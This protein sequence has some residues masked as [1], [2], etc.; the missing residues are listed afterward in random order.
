M[1]ALRRQDACVVSER[2]REDLIE[3]RGDGEKGMS[4]ATIVSRGQEAPVLGGPQRILGEG[5]EQVFSEDGSQV[6]QVG[7]SG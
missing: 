4:S 2:G 5:E 1:S 3:L 6:G 7:G